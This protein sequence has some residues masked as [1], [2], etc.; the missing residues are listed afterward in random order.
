MPRR[1]SAAATPSESAGA[2]VLHIITVRPVATHGSST[3][4]SWVCAASTT[5]VM[6]TSTCSATSRGEAAR[7]APAAT[8]SASRPG[9]RSRT[10]TAN[11]FAS[12]TFATPMPIAPTPMTPTRITLA[13][14]L[15]QGRGRTSS[16]ALSGGGRAET[17]APHQG[18]DLRVAPAEGAITLGGIDRVAHGEDVRAQPPGD[19]LVVRATRLRGQPLVEKLRGEFHIVAI[20]VGA[21]KRRIFHARAD[22][23]QRVAEFMEQRGRVAPAHQHRLARLA[24]DEIAVVR[25]QGGDLAVEALLV[26]VGVHPGARALALAR[27]RIEVEERDVLAGLVPHF[28]DAHVGVVDGN[29][30]GAREAQAE[31]L[32]R[33]PEHRLA[34]LLELQVGR[35]SVVVDVE[36]GLAHLLGVVA[37]VPG[38]D[39]NVHA[40]LLGHRLHVDDFLAH[41][42]DGGL[43]Q[44][45][46]ELRGALGRL[47]H[48]HLDAPVRVAGIAEDMRTFV[49]QLHDFGNDRLV[50]V[51]VAVV[52]AVGERA[53]DLL[54]QLA[55]VRVREERID[56]RARVEDRPLAGLA[57]PRRRLGS[58]R[59]ER[60]GQSRE[61]AFFL[62]EDVARLV[63]KQV[64]AEPGVE[65]GEPLVERGELLLRG[66]VE[67]GASAGEVA[68]LQ[69]REP[70]LFGRELRSLARVVHRRDPLEELLVLHD[71]VAESGKLRLHLAFDGLECLGEHGRAE[72]AVDARDAV[73]H[74]PG[75]LERRDRVLERRRRRTVVD[76]PDL[77]ELL[78][79]RLLERRLEVRDFDLVERRHP[80]VGS[81][82]ARQKG[83][84]HGTSPQTLA[85]GSLPS[86]RVS[87]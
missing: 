3:S 75:A 72:D 65:R 10:T 7:F 2:M 27:V 42:R 58:P 73:E 31:Q 83:I 21:R 36:A 33:D 43:P 81:A 63:G 18:V 46:H 77:A 80:T 74:A 38:L 25:D 40:V 20:D 48:A 8:A 76:A 69:P 12:S 1:A 32:A 56:A 62:N 61:V 26:A 78:L 64:L 52:A 23:V 41:A 14:A 17:S 44:G 19:R 59:T 37:V 49:A 51:L 71:E 45:L 34:Q 55:P 50:V 16:L 60:L 4:T 47:R 29:A 70:L 39:R 79:H 54:A 66:R 85:R 87:R 22:A 35:D 28:P 5:S 82:P 11:P 15:S 6:S 86:R 84:F 67:L 13:P 30:L 9:T 53:P 57:A 68:V 24:L